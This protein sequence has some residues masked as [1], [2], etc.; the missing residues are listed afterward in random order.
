MDRIIFS[1]QQLWAA[2][3]SPAALA[4]AIESKFT[5]DLR[6]AGLK[7]SSEAR[8]R[9]SWSTV[10]SRLFEVYHRVVEQFSR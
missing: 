3:N 8:G 10:F 4:D 9:Y 5:L 7:A 2:E 6:A 1:D